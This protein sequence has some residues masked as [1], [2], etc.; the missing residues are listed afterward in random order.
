MVPDRSVS[1]LGIEDLRWCGG[2]GSGDG[3]DVTEEEEEEVEEGAV[4]GSRARSLVEGRADRASDKRCL[5][6]FSEVEDDLR[7]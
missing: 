6:L 2:S 3:V 5:F 7:V 4:G 1:T